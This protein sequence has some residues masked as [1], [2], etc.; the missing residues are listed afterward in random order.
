MIDYPTTLEESKKY[1]YGQWAGY[2]QGN[3]YREGD[4]AYEVWS[5]GRGMTASQCQHK[6]GYGTNGLYCKIHAQ[7]LKM[8]EGPKPKPRHKSFID[9][10]I[11]RIKVL[12]S[13][14]KN[15]RADLK[16]LQ[17]KVHNSTYHI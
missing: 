14:N 5:G 7:K 16:I 15:L 10:L 9:T 13:E 8:I 3:K 6:N 2:P 11:D 1:R 17:E 4:C 12:E